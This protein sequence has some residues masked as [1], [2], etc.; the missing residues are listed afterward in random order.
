M[1]YEK[2]TILHCAVL[3]LLATAGMA[4][5][6]YLVSGSYSALIAPVA[7]IAA[8]SFFPMGLARYFPLDKKG[9]HGKST[10]KAPQPTPKPT[11][12]E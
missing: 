8:I 1:R 7:G 10:G 2:V 9:K 5:N 6:Q 4:A 11:H 12:A 3:P